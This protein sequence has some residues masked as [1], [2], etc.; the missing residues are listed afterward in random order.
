MKI[1]QYLDAPIDKEIRNKTSTKNTSF[2]HSCNE[3]ISII[4]NNDD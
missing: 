4:E 2:E 3:N 1:K